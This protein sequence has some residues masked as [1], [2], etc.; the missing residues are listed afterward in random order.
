MG[1][2]LVYCR[3]QANARISPGLEDHGYLDLLVQG[4]AFGLDVLDRIL[5]FLQHVDLPNR[6]GRKCQGKDE[7]AWL[8]DLRKMEKRNKKNCT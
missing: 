1:Y 4:S 2:H 3:N 8:G 6:V 7:K 5:N